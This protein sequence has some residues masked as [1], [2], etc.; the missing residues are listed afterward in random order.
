M[1]K[2]ARTKEHLREAWISSLS[3]DENYAREAAENLL[4]RFLIPAEAT[5]MCYRI[6]FLLLSILWKKLSIPLR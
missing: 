2:A 4:Q 6:T 1:G 3:K 5:G